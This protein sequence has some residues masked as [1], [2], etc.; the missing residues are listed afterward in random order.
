MQSTTPRPGAR[1]A[2]GRPALATVPAAPIAV[3]ELPLS[4]LAQFVGD[5]AGARVLAALR[6]RGHGALRTA[7]GF[8]IQHLLGG[9]RTI[10]ELAAL[11]GISQQAVS[12]TVA[13]LVAARYAAAVATDDRRQRRVALTRRGRAAVEVGRGARAA[14]EVELRRVLGPRGFAQAH[15]ALARLIEHLGAGDAVRQRRVRPT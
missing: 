5:A 13:E 1:R 10:G 15:R 3:A 9:P 14:L 7:H 6:R 8:V 11:L 12:K 2:G 4:Y